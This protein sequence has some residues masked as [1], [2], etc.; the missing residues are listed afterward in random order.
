MKE[1]GIQFLATLA[2]GIVLLLL[3][4]AYIQSKGGIANYALSTGKT[5]DTIKKLFGLQ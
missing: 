4:D 3:T 1:F 2:A 5:A